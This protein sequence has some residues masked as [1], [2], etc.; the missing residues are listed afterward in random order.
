MNFS[1]IVPFYNNVSHINRLF[2]TLKDYFNNDLCEIIIVDDCSK[3]KDF[4]AL[5]GYINELK[6]NNIYLIRNAKNGG[7]AFSRQEG[8]KIAKGDYI[9]FLD[10]DD[11]WVKNRAFILYD[12]IIQH[13][14]NIIGG[15]TIF[16]DEEE[17]LDLRDTTFEISS[18]K[19]LNFNKFLFK[20]Y[21]STPTVMVRKDV[22][23]KNG[24]DIS[25]RYSEDYECWRRIILDGRA[26][27]LKN[28]GT[29]SFKHPYI[30]Q[31]Y[32]SLS[33]NTLKMSKGELQG[34]V[35]L[36]NNPIISFS[37]KL[38]ILVAL[39]YSAIKAVVREIRVMIKL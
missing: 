6:A 39:I 28:A 35:K 29:Y 5:E 34:L 26:F 25:M 36:L 14:I 16:I 27:F 15:A 24:F 38:L 31:Q 11:G 33:S 37:N 1:I 17:F 13:S 22:F 19:L 3:E 7:A 21:F 2:L 12:Y 9:A 8:V 20:N 23:I 4:T 10:A 32:G 30:S 18:P